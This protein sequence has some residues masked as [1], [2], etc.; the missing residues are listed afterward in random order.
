MRS[1][2]DFSFLND[3][4]VGYLFSDKW[5][6]AILLDFINSTIPDSGMKTFRDIKILTPF[7]YKEN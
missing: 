1:N 7:N 3:Y 6:E 4:F 5:S 2:K